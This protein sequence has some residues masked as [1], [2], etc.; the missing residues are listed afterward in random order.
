M[1]IL[2]HNYFIAA[3]IPVS[4]KSDKMPASFERR[5]RSQISRNSQN[6]NFPPRWR[7]KEIPLWKTLFRI[8]RKTSSAI[9]SS[10]TFLAFLRDQF[11]HVNNFVGRITG[12]TGDY[13]D[14]AVACPRIAI[15]F[16]FRFPP[17]LVLQKNFEFSLL[18]FANTNRQKMAVF[19]FYFGI[20]TNTNRNRDCSVYK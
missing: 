6:L 1:F 9:L 14:G 8:R 19:S 2:F 4:T 10:R 3:Q 7:S 15:F 5:R 18:Q 16:N 20:F 17:P 13:D 11:G 12:L